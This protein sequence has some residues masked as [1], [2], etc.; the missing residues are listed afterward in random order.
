MWHLAVALFA[1]PILSQVRLNG[2]FS[3]QLASSHYWRMRVVH[4]RR[5]FPGSEPCRLD[6]TLAARAFPRLALG[7]IGL[8]ERLV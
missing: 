1:I 6:P 2:D 4:A 3:N 7:L 5:V 8:D